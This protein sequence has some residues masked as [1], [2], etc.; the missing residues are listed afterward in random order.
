MK[1]TSG[2]PPSVAGAE[3]TDVGRAPTDAGAA[4]RM[5]IHN[6]DGSVAEACGNGTRC[7]AALL[8][9]ES[10]AA[11]VTI[12]TLAGQLDCRRADDGQIAVDMGPVQLAALRSSLTSTPRSLV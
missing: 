4:V 3:E 8:M 2:P 5:D 10:G 7:V 12:E 9:E 6:P 11:A 1:K